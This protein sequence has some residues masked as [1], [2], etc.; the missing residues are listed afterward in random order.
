MK[1]L[2]RR[3]RPFS[4]I[5]T[6]GSR[7]ESKDLYIRSNHKIGPRADELISDSDPHMKNH[8]L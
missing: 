1:Q 7:A 3:T 5:M 6:V 4:C 8:V 2:V